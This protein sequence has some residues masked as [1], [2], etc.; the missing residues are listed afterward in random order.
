[1]RQFTVA[2]LEDVDECDYATMKEEL[3]AFTIILSEREQDARKATKHFSQLADDIYLFASRIDLV[4]E[5]A[6]VHTKETLHAAKHRMADLHVGLEQISS[7]TNKMAA[8]CLASFR[9]PA[10]LGV[11]VAVVTLSPDT[12]VRAIMSAAT[13]GHP[14]SSSQFVKM[15][16]R[17]NDLTTEMKTCSKEIM[18]LMD[19]A[20]MLGHYK[21]LLI[22]MQSELKEHSSKIDIFVNIWRSLKMDLYSFEEQLRHTV[23]S[24]SKITKLFQMKIASSRELYTT[25]TFSFQQYAKGFIDKEDEET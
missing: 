13:L 2:M 1:M 5:D 6:D 23:S 25:L 8:A 11:G 7:D 10:I 20:D 3:E 24:K 9:A 15:R 17:K 19:Q 18:Q 4:H 16:H 21:A 14:S 12:F 22:R